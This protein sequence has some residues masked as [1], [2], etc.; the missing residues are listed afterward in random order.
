M[1]L[2]S[3]SG[4]EK[5]HILFIKNKNKSSQDNINKI[6]YYSKIQVNANVSLY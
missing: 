3:K 4:E 5:Q 2:A 6:F 1:K